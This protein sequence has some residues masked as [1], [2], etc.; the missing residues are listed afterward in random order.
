MKGKALTEQIHRPP[1]TTDVVAHAAAARVRQAN[2]C[3]L[4]RPAQ[5]ECRDVFLAVVI[6]HDADYDRHRLAECV[7]RH[8]GRR[9]S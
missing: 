7:L 3:V 5:G 2:A 4:A 1:A 9:S 6:P 8:A